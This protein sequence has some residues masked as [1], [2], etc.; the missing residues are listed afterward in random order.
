MLPNDLIGPTG[1]ML[2]GD[3]LLNLIQW[4]TDYPNI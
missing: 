1:D 3:T 2:D 4:P